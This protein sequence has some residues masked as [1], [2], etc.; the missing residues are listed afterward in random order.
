MA[1]GKA[2]GF[3]R[4]S[5]HK[6]AQQTTHPE[7]LDTGRLEFG[8]NFPQDARHAFGE[9][10]ARATRGCV[11]RQP[12]EARLQTMYRVDL[13]YTRRSI[14]KQ[15]DTLHTARTH[16]LPARRA[17]A[18][19]TLEWPGPTT[20]YIVCNRASEGVLLRKG[21]SLHVFREGHVDG[22]HARDLG[23]RIYPE[24]CTDR[25]SSEM[26]HAGMSSRLGSARLLTA[27]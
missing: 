2:D 20:R 6:T 24:I 27:S 25:H 16:H 5:A 15:L 4:L 1:F 21:L 18:V 8:A 10:L 23:Y 17:A 26:D 3:D 22:D 14:T 13:I 7:S 9:W 11:R 19:R 12:S